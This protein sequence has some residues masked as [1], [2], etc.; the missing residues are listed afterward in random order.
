MKKRILAILLLAIVCLLSS[1][2]ENDVRVELKDKG[3][4]TVTYSYKLN[5][6]I[7]DEYLT[8][9][10]PDVL[11]G[12]DVEEIDGEAYYC[13]TESFECSDNAELEAKIKELSMLGE[14]SMP[15]FSTVDVEDNYIKLT[16]SSGII[17]E[18]VKALAQKE[19]VD[20]YELVYL[21]LS[22]TMPS[23]IE[24]YSLGAVSEDKKSLSVRFDDLSEENT[25]EVKSIS[26]RKARIGTIRF[27]PQRYVEK[28]R[29]I[30]YDAS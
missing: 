10:A 6:I 7:A 26:H 9:K 30:R 17:S 8:G 1:C 3:G 21:E 25:L 22:I 29:N 5:K 18:D 14:T 13:K 24:T 4:G 11:H 23:E 28:K 20:I 2:V 19:K 15:F 12:A 16:T 27:N